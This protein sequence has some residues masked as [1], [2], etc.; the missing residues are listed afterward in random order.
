MSSPTGTS[1][2]QAHAMIFEI[3][4]QYYLKIS[5][6]KLSNDRKLGP[7]TRRQ[8]APGDGRSGQTRQ[9]LGRKT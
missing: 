6:E 8:S 9:F 4:F 7:A 1:Q 5:F 2:P 3:Q